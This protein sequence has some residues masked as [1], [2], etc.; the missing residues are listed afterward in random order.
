MEKKERKEPQPNEQEE[1]ELPATFADESGRI[2]RVRLSIPLVLEFCGEHNVP[3]RQFEPSRLNMKQMFELAYRGT[4][5]ETK[6]KASPV[7]LTEWTE[8]IGESAFYPAIH[9]TANEVINFTLRSSLPK[10]K[11]A[12]GV[13]T[14]LTVAEREIR[15][16]LEAAGV[17]MT[18]SKSAPSP[19]S[20]QDE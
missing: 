20:S 7:T 16:E 10:S 4:R 2:W 9:A 13:R 18:S 6:A 15:K 12:E 3:M 17:E 11:I 19:E 5:W 1:T 8:E 14:V